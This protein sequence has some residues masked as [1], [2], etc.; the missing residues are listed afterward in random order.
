MTRIL[1]LFFIVGCAH[2]TPPAPVVTPKPEPPKPLPQRN[3]ICER[4]ALENE[5]IPCAPESTDRG[6]LHWHRA[7]ILIDGQYHVC[8]LNDQQPSAVCVPLFYAPQQPPEPEKKPEPE[9]KPASPAK[10]TPKAK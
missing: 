5:K 9:T 3:L 8:T 7:R 10:K 4:L 6:E 2:A 1:V